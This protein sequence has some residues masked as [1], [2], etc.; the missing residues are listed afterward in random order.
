MA[1]A[2]VNRELGALKRMF[3]LASQQ[4]P[5]LAP[6]TTMPY[7]PHL[8]E[9]NVRRGFFTEDEYKVPRAALPDHLKVPF[10]LGY[11][12]GMRA[13]QILSL[14]WE[15]VEW[16]RGLLRLE[17]GATK[18]GYGRLVPLTQ[19]VRAM[20]T[21]WREH[22]LRR[23]PT[24][25]WVCHYRGASMER[26]QKKTWDAACQVVG[27]K[28]KLF[29][30]LRRTAVRE[31]VRSGIPERV[32]MQISGHRTRSVFDRYHIVSEADLCEAIKRLD[33]RPRPA[34]ASTISSTVREAEMREPA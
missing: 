32:A 5:P 25:R 8:R 20:L 30:D 17:P 11:W 27:L 24:C 14:R 18:N 33:Q 10:I 34:A 12:T 23:Y 16:E 15:Q 2:T 4:T 19:E 28:G 7:V 21:Q 22:T 13:G 1:N 31:M 29:H 6:L 3:R 26:I 9:D